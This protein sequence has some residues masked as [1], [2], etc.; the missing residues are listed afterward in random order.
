MLTWNLPDDLCQIPAGKMQTAKTIYKY[1]EGT[2]PSSLIDYVQ[3]QTATIN[4]IEFA[5]YH[6]QILNLAYGFATVPTYT[7][8]DSVARAEMNAII[9]NLIGALDCMSHEI[10]TILNLQINEREVTFGH[11]HKQGMNNCIICR[12]HTTHPQVANFL[13][14]IITNDWF[15]ELKE[16]RNHIH[17]RLPVIQVSM[18]VGGPFRKITLPDDPSNYNP[19][20]PDYS[21]KLEIQEYCRD[22]IDK[23]MAAIEELYHKLHP[24]IK[25]YVSTKRTAN[26]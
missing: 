8:Q 18:V 16:Y 22:R 11:N 4:R 26:P 17:K 20:L 25:Q 5:I 2:I 9:L 6:Y 12:I 3:M 19:Q 24:Q 14:S 13:A 10:N 23:V 7:Q 21:K 1:F 15:K